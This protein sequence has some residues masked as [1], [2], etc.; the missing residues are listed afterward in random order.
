MENNSQIYNIFE[1]LIR[2]KKFFLSIIE[3]INDF[4][5]FMAIDTLTFLKYER[6]DKIAHTKVLPLNS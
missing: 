5:H 1:M 4:D 6:N 3:Y 2:S